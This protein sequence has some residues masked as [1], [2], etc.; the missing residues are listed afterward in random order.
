LKNVEFSGKKKISADTVIDLNGKTLNVS[1][2]MFILKS[3]TSEYEVVVKNG[4]ITGS[5]TGD[6]AGYH[7]FQVGNKGSL[8]LENINMN[9]TSCTGVFLVNKANP[10]S[11]E[12]KNSKI[13]VDGGYGIGT[14]A[15]NAEDTFVSVK[16]DNSEIIAF[17]S[18]DDNTGMLINVPAT[19]L[20]SDSTISGERQGLILRGVDTEHEKKIINSTIESTG[21]LTTGYDWT[22]GTWGVGN[23]VPLAALVIG[24]NNTSGYPFG[25]KVE[26][27]NVTLKVG[28]SAVRKSLYVYQ[29]TDKDGNVLPVTVTGTINGE[30]TVND[31]TNGALLFPEAKVG[32]TYYQTLDAA[33]EAAN[34]GDTIVI[35]DCSV[36]NE[37]PDNYADYNWEVI[38]NNCSKADDSYWHEKSSYFSA[39]YGTKV[40]PYMISTKDQFKKVSEMYQKYAYYKISD[41]YTELD[42][43]D[44]EAVDLTGSFDGNGK[45]FTN[46]T[47]SLFR[48]VGYYKLNPAE[49]TL[50]NFDVTFSIYDDSIMSSNGLVVYIDNSGTTIFEDISLHG[51]IEFYWNSGSFY[52]YGPWKSY[53]A[54]FVN[55]KSDVTLICTT[56]N[57]GGGFIGHGSEGA[58]NLLT[59]YID[60]NSS[61]TGKFYTV[62]GNGYK[63]MGMCSNAKVKFNDKE[64]NRYGSTDDDKAFVAYADNNEKIQ[65]VLP[66]L[67]DSGYTVNVDTSA[68]KIVASVTASLTAYDEN[69]KVISDYNGI[70]MILGSKTIKVSSS[71]ESPVLLLDNV[72]SAT[73]TKNADA[74]GYTLNNGEMN[75]NVA[76]SV[77]Y[78]TGPIYLT[79]TQYGSDGVVTSCGTV[80]VYE[81]TK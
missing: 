64:I 17:S 26:L 30:Y 16:I 47:T 73:I 7:I 49:L 46:V 60:E 13:N 81:I 68:S 37:V 41:D 5:N 33:V 80:K 79:V 48:Y 75:V 22:S 8:F 38:H 67:G 74:Y 1:N 52:C 58:N 14:N 6:C 43:S 12:V 76:T 2:G 39:G 23:R 56:G 59:L 42:L 19:V 11:V 3:S 25:T 78:Q 45:K 28:E 63:Y 4:N 10:A 18:D 31:D 15:T 53:T 66:V 29:D 20:I 21:T 36:S 54:K 51:T 44:W 27:D 9:V 72:T 69:G 77:N 50:K 24:D 35:L 71:T 65:Q 34:K 62:Q 70:T 61:Y 40:E 32:N 55:C 57:T